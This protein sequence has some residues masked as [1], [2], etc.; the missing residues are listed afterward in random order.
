LS[1]RGVYAASSSEVEGHLE[2]PYLHSF[3]A[4]KRRKR[5][6]PI[7]GGRAIF[8][9]QAANRFPMMRVMT[10]RDKIVGQERL[11]AWRKVQC[12]HHRKVVVTNGCFDI[13]HAGHVSYLEAARALGDVLLVGVTNDAAV[14][15]LKGDGRP[16]NTEADR[17]AVLAALQS[18]DAVCIFA[19]RTATNFLREA[20]PDIYVKGG[21]YTIDTINQEE[22]RSLEARGVRIAI[23]PLVPGQSTTALL[24]KITQL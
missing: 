15:A 13:L 4:V 10:F 21:D 19:E 14:G 12:A 1:E 24:Q 7:T 8:V 23:L 17:A 6:A 20:E 11:A 3:P 18:V 9:C 2:S 22:R 5:R 16:V